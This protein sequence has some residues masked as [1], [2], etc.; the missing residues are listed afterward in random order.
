MERFFKLLRE[1]AMIMINFEA[2]KKMK[3]KKYCKVRDQCHY[4]GEYEGAARS[5][6]NSKYSAPK[7]ISI[8]FHI[9]S[10]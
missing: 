5:I 10:N 7:K 2:K 4:T 8:T 6:C 1:H 3:D 9:A